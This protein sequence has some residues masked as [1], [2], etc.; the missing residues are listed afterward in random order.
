MAYSPKK[1]SK[2][3]DTVANLKQG[4]RISKETVMKT[5]RDGTRVT[6]DKY[7]NISKPTR[8]NKPPVLP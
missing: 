5:K 1:E 8:P 7:G 3:G 4:G 6:K 2:E